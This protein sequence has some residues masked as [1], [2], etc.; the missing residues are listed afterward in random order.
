MMQ[1]TARHISNGGR[2]NH[3]TRHMLGL[4]KGRAGSRK[5]RQIMTVDSCKPDANELV[6][7]RAFAAVLN[8]ETMLSA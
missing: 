5:Y 6:I 7:E 8:G 3:V 4:F 2:A 1:Y